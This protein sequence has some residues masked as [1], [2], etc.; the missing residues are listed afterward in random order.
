M[1]KALAEYEP[2][3]AA[4]GHGLLFPNLGLMG[5]VSPMVG[6]HFL[7][8]HPRGPERHEIWQW[9]MV[10]REA[11][12]AVKEL[13]V[14]RVYQGQH[15]AGVVAPDDVENFERIVEASH[16]PRTWTTPMNLEIHLGHDQDQLPHLPGN[17]GAEP[18]EV[19]QREFYR[20]WLELMQSNAG[21]QGGTPD[22]D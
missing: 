16:S 13:A 17:I 8:F 1:S 18:S 20:F 10:E 15:M 12:Q 11:P 14:Q 4:F 9:T 6:K 5:Y 19:N 7:Q 21:E 22:A 2:R 3:P